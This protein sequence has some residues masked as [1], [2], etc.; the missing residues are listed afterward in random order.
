MRKIDDLI[1]TRLQQVVLAA[2]FSL[3]RSHRPAPR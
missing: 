3:C 1:E 2:L